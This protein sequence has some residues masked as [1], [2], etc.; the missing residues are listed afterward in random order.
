[1]AGDLKMSELVEFQSARDLMPCFGYTQ[2]RNFSGVI[3]R[4]MGIIKHKSL[5]GE[6]IE[7]RCTVRIGSGAN[8]RIVDY[9]LDLEAVVLLKE[10]CSSYKLNNFFSIRNETVVLQLVEKYCHKKHISFQYQFIVENRLFDCMVNDDILIEFDEPHHL[11]NTRQKV[12]DADKDIVA[13]VNGFSLY[14][15][16]LGM[17]IVD[18]IL[19][20]ESAM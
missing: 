1:M 19:H 17:D 7:T 11:Y 3:E 12:I 20:L 5:C 8:R 2:W 16:D 13:E 18:I 14:R 15:V 6:I 9:L 10:L 4:A